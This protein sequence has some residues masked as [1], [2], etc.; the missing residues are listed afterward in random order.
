[1]ESQAKFSLV[2]TGVVQKASC[3]LLLINVCA[4]SELYRGKFNMGGVRLLTSD[5]RVLMM[6]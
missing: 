6:D 4:I 1:M 2:S 3:R 5:D